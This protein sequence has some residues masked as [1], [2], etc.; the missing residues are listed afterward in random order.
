LIRS[1]GLFTGVPRVLGLAAPAPTRC[2]E[3]RRGF[4]YGK[5]RWHGAHL[6]RTLEAVSFKSAD[7]SILLVKT[8]PRFEV[9]FLRNDQVRQHGHQRDTRG[10]ESATEL[11]GSDA[12]LDRIPTVEID[13][14]HGI[15]VKAILVF[16]VRDLS[17]PPTTTKLISH[18]H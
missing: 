5:P 9:S 14:Y 1:R 7:T 12:Q 17:H 11:E 3:P 18:S 4:T 16:A 13:N 10:K 15:T 2:I 8:S 6:P